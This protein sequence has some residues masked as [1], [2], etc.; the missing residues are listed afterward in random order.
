[1]TDLSMDRFVRSFAQGKVL[2]YGGWDR[3][4]DSWLEAVNARPGRVAIVRYEDLLGQGVQALAGPLTELG[5][6]FRH[7]RILEAW[8]NNSADRMRMKERATDASA[9]LDGGGAG[10]HAVPFVRAA[11]S[12]QWRETLPIELS[13]MLSSRFASTIERL[14]YPLS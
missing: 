4:T 13:D 7:D 8:E 1:M 12:G 10:L 2:S 3:H 11:T 5:F 9:F 6:E 14:G